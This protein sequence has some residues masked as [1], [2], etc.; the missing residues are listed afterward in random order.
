MNNVYTLEYPIDKPIRI[1]AATADVLAFDATPVREPQ[2]RPD[3][4]L[5]EWLDEA[6]YN[7]S[8]A[9]ATFDR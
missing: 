5:L 4:V 1:R 8:D 9:P 3:D 7:W 2:A 6:D